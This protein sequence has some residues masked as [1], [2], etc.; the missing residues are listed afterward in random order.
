[1]EALGARH[2]RARTIP[3]TWGIIAG[4]ERDCVLSSAVRA[5]EYKLDRDLR[6]AMRL[7]MTHGYS[8]SG[9][10]SNIYVQSLCRAL[11]NEG[12]D[13][14]L[15]CQEPDPLA[16]D[17]VGKGAGVDAGGV[18]VLGEHEP[19]SPELCGVYPP[20]IGE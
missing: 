7:I 15:L 16:F 11:V 19:R 8:L 2:I 10:G 1:M 3:R 14:H 12:H 13:V 18:E 6:S 20:E 9:T 4:P 17:F 5:W